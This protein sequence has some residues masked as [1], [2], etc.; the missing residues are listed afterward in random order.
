M[1][2]S[3]LVTLTVVTTMPD[4][5]KLQPGDYK[6]TLLSNPRAP[7]VEFYRDGK[8]VCKCPVKLASNSAKPAATQL[9]FGVTPSGEHILQTVTVKRLDAVSDFLDPDGA[10]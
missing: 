7:Q 1:G 4:G 9:L 5:A 3:T 6:M 10:W 2:S 8:L